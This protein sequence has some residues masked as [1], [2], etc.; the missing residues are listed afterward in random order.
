MVNFIRES[1]EPEFGVKFGKRQPTVN[2]A[3]G[4]QS[5]WLGT[6]QKKTWLGTT[7]QK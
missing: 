6:V 4:P 3:K 7:V 5:T 2:K 1:K